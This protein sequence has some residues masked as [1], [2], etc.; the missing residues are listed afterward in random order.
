MFKTI[1]MSYVFKNYCGIKV[2]GNNSTKG[3]SVVN[4][5]KVFKFLELSRKEENY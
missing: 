5:V 3:G 4:G 1:L 2:F